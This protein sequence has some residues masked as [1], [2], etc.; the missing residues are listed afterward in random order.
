MR[1]LLFVSSHC[2]HCPKAE[3]VAKGVAPEYYN[4]GMRFEKIRLKTE[5]GKRLSRELNIMSTPTILMLDDNGVETE[6]IVGIPSETSLKN[7]IESRLGLKKT[8][9]SRIL[10]R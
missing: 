5:E 6:R 3:S 9:L 8:L 4:Y 7:K 10:G 1:M 2:P